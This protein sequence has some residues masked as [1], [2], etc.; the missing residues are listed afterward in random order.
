MVNE[1][2]FHFTWFVDCHE[3]RCIIFM[4]ESSLFP[5]DSCCTTLVNPDASFRELVE[6]ID[7][8]QSVQSFSNAD[9]REAH[10]LSSFEIS[11]S[12]H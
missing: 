2:S 11:G 5:S 3:T 4:I 9:G 12:V 7:R 10:V 1:D 8:T 6:D